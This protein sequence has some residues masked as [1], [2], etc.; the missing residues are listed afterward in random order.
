MMALLRSEPVMLKIVS[1]RKTK[2]GDYRFPQKRD[3]RHR[4]SLNSNLNPFAF[5]ITLIHEMA[6][7]KAF[8]DYG[9]K[10]KAHGPESAAGI[11]G[12][13]PAL[14]SSHY[15]SLRSSA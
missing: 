9:H 4:I 13:L 15:F 1:P 12:P 8:K 7:L 2:F 3:P 10:I 14:L 6:H 5:L 11:L